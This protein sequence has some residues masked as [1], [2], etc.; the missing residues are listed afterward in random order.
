MNLQIP[1]Q[2]ILLSEEIFFVSFSS[3]SLKGAISL[4]PLKNINVYDFEVL[5][6][7]CRLIRKCCISGYKFEVRLRLLLIWKYNIGNLNFQA[8]SFAV[9]WVV[10]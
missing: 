7:L 1:I 6:S 5:S 4:S 2:Q 9:A 3:E 10:I 8:R